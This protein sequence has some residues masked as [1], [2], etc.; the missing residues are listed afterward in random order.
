MFRALATLVVGRV[1]ILSD[2]FVVILLKAIDATMVTPEAKLHHVYTAVISL[3][4][5]RIISIT[6][7]EIRPLVHCH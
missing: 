4:H 6:G 3:V 2:E 5:R 7:D 1:Y